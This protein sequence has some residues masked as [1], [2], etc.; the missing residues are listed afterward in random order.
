MPPSPYLQRL[1][2]PSLRVPLCS[3]SAAYWLHHFFLSATPLCSPP[4]QPLCSH[5]G[6]PRCSLLGPLSAPLYILNPRRAK[7]LHAQQRFFFIFLFFI[8]CGAMF[9]PFTAIYCKYNNFLEILSLFVKSLPRCIYF[10]SIK[11]AF[12]SM[13]IPR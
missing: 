9:R 1:C 8:H 11:E 10:I 3:P 4:R 5:L 13:E 12:L 6:R 2:H 7:I